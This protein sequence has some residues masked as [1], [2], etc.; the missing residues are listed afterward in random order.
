MANFGKQMLNILGEIKGTG[1]FVSSGVQPFLFPGLQIRGMDEIGFPINATQI[2]ALINL[3]HQAPF[4]KGSKTVLDKAVRSAWEIDAGQIKFVNKE[5]GGF[6]EGIVRQIKPA[7]G[8]DGLSVSANLYKLLIYQKGDF[9]LPHKD[10]EKELGM[11]G[12]L[13]I[14]L[15]SSHKGGELVVNFDGCSETIDFSDPVNR[16]QIPFAAFYADCEHEI[17][18]I[19]SGYRV[20][21]VYNLVQ[22]KGDEKIQPEKLNDQVKKLAALLKASEEDLDIPKIVLLGHQYTPSNFT[23]NALKLND[24]HKAE[25]LIRAA[26]LAGFYIKPGL[27][28]SYQ[29]GELME[30]DTKQ[31]S[32]GRNYR[33]RNRYYEEY[34]HE[35]LTE[36]GIIGEV[37]DEHVGIEHWMKGGIPPLRNIQFDEMDLISAITLNAGEPIQKAAEGYTGNAG[38]E[39]QYWY[40]YGAIFLWPRKYHYDMVIDLDTD[41]KLEWIDYYN[42]HWGTLT[43]VDIALTRKLVEGGM[44]VN[45]LKEKVDYSPLADWLINLND[46][47]YLLKKGSKFLTDHFVRIAVDKWIKLVKHYPIDKFED[48]FLTVGNKKDVPVV[49]HLLLIFNDL[50]ADN[51][52]SAK[53]FV[54]QQASC[55]PG[56]L[57]NLKLTAESEKKAVREIL[58]SLLQIDEKKVIKEKNWHRKITAALTKKLTREYVNDILI[59]E[60]LCSGN[61]SNLAEQ[62]LSVCISDLQRRVLDKPKP[63]ISWSRPVPKKS[64]IYG[65]VWDIL[66]DFLKSATLQIFD[67]QAIL[68]KRNEMEYAIRDVVID[69][70]METI[71]KGSPHIL[72]LTKTQYA[73]ER[74]LAKWKEDVEILG[75]MK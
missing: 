54:G 59:A 1:S 16:Y 27:V 75:K 30:D 44:P 6:V 70:K 50:L 56:Y 64:G 74:E 12:S 39:M 14:G 35:N 2:K 62:L 57:E 23:M 32:A 67:Y 20:C 66:A 22:T 9:F 4:G 7:M 13:I 3:A 73:Y 25:A 46:E 65:Y 72:R 47:K 58:R 45:H 34:D 8:L 11:F 55:I 48:I 31:S 53:T 36:N 68:E 37:Y 15:P 51:N 63:P 18:P 5:W 49:R 43:K 42:Q 24:R 10:S 29:V 17:R 40:H 28:T 26:E 41:N 71:R 61:K 21:L 52:P 38:M 19:T 69:I 60:I 33:K